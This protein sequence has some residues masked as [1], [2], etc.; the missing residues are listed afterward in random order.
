M[1]ELTHRKLR[2]SDAAFA[3]ETTPKAIRNWLQ[4]DLVRLAPSSSEGWREFSLMDVAALALV[5]RFVD[6]G[7]PVEKANEFAH[8][9]LDEKADTLL[10][11][12][13]T[14]GKALAAS[15][16]GLSAI[17]WRKDG[18]EMRLVYI[19]TPLPPPSDSFLV[20]DIGASLRRA[21]ER[22]LTGKS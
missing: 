12:K 17:I 22:A 14:P 10:R 5:R 15:F 11:F 20:V 7:L 3:A 1:N 16:A 9:I 13:N 6:F 21:T 19:A 2:L 4:R 18:W 8:E